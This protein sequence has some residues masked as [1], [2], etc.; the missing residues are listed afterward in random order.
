MVYRRQNALTAA[1]EAYERAVEIFPGFA[2]AYNNLGAISSEVAERVVL[3]RQA[4]EIKPDLAESW[5]NLALAYVEQGDDKLAWIC[6]QK[7]QEMN[8]LLPADLVSQVQRRL[9]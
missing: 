7:C 8:Y 1:R 9:Q 5:K 6:I 3:F 2:E 4:I